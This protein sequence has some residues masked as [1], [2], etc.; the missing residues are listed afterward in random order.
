MTFFFCP[1]RTPIM[2]FELGT[3]R[4]VCMHQRLEFLKICNPWAP[5]TP[6]KMEF[7]AQ[8]HPEPSRQ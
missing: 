5:R 2:L 6:I 7:Q 3:S 4:L 8:T 1:I